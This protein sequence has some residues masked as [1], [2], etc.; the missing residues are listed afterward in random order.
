MAEAASLSTTGDESVKESARADF[1]KRVEP[2]VSQA[3]KAQRRIEHRETNAFFAFQ[4]DRGVLVP[5]LP[6]QKITRVIFTA[7]IGKTTLQN[8]RHLAAPMSVF[9]NT[10]TCSNAL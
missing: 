8:Q 5:P 1:K 10:A 7:L 2:A 3:R 4:R 6:N 9:R